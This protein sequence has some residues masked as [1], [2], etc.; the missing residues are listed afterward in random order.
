MENCTYLLLG[1]SAAAVM[2]RWWR[3]LGSGRRRT[4][5]V[6][7]VLYSGYNLQVEHALVEVWEET[8]LK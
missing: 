1:I 2:V 6:S 3:V 8:L 7:D 4:K 5:N